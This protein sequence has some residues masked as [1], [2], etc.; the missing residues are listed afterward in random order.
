MPLDS[1]IN[2]IFDPKRKCIL[3]AWRSNRWILKDNKGELIGRVAAFIN[4]KKAYTY[5]VPTGGMGFFEC[6]NDKNA[7]PVI[8]TCCD[9]LK[10]KGMQAMDGH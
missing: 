10:E 2:A 4:N 1:D 8:D 5:D 7:L 9:W 3:Y 6:I